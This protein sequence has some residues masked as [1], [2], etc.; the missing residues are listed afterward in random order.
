METNYKLLEAPEGISN[1]CHDKFE[2]QF[3]SREQTKKSIDTEINIMKPEIE[4]VQNE[5]GNLYRYL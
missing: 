3:H 1:D 5:N 4:Q 2:D